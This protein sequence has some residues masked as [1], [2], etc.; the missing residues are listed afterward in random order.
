MLWKIARRHLKR[1]PGRTGLT[2]LGVASAVLLFVCIESLSQGLQNALNAG[3]AA[4]TLVVYR[5]NRYCPQTSFLPER[6]SDLIRE[7]KGV[8]SVLPVKVYLS[9]CRASLDVVAF[10]GAPV[11]TLFQ[12][13]RIDLVEGDLDRFRRED[14]AA[15]VGQEFATRRGLE[16]GDRFRF[17]DVTV[18]VAGV[19][20]SDDPVEEGLIVTHLEFLQ[21]AGPVSRLGTVTQFEVKLGDARNADRVAS[22]IDQLFRTAE[23]PTSTRPRVEF[24]GDATRELYE[25]LRF[26]RAFG[27]ICVLVVIVLVA[28]TVLLSVQERSREFGVYLTL[29]YGGQHLL[30]LVTLETLALTL[31]G[32]LLGLLGAVL[33]VH[34]SHLAIGVE[35]VIVTFALT[36]T[37]L[38]K[39]ILVALLA[40]LVA[41]S[42]PALRAARSDPRQLLAKA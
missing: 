36:A 32:A 24:L 7:V 17:G 37:G 42:Y 30:W 33:V 26:G 19:F 35:G 28:N 15:L 2:V 22:E 1:R 12:T 38:L 23:E 40:A 31:G 8:E 41:A 6:Y 14:D 29:G 10:H 5:M 11:E 16:V 4:R 34:F 9:N 3:D 20:R 21:R 39:A 18:D 13:R 25:I 27:L